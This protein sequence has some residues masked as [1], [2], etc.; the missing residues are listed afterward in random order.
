MKKILFSAT[1]VS[2]VLGLTTHAYANGT[3]NGFTS[4]TSFSSL[5]SG[6]VNSTCS[7]TVTDGALPVNQGFTSTLTTPNTNKGKISTICNSSNSSIKVEIDS[8]ASIHPT[9]PNYNEDFE[10][11]GG[12]GAY[13]A[14]LP[15]GFGQTPYLKTNLTNGF[16]TTASTIDV[17]ARARVPLNQYLS[18][19]NYTVSIKATVTP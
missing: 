10:L 3:S 11:S 12:T 2:A 5:H 16:S 6:S 4:S 8:V 18:A 9:Q 19:G 1:V 14:G 17:R 7:L 15:V 13:S